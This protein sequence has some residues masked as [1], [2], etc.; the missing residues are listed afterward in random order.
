MTAQLDHLGVRY[1][2]LVYRAHHPGWAYLPT[3]GE[4]AKRH[5]GRF[6]RKGQTALYTSLDLT[7]AWLDAQQGF[8]FKAQPMTLVA[9][10]VR[11]ERVADLTD[12]D[13]LVAAS[14][15]PADLGCA[16][17]DLASRGLRAPTWRI[18][19]ALLAAGFQGALVPS[20]APALNPAPTPAQRRNLVFWTWASAA[21]C[22]VQVIDDFGRLPKDAAS[23]EVSESAAETTPITASNS[24][25]VSCAVLRRHCAHCV[26]AG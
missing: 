14:I 8:P 17:E 24:T 21:P 18:A 4:G 6:N 10:Q 23:W 11:C 3:S 7:T 12:L 15:D 1:H 22:S 20:F 26:A 13:R 25:S 16:W 2:G 19:D 9:Y 5:G